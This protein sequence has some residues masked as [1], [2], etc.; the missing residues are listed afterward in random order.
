MPRHSQFA[1]VEATEDKP[2][3]KR[4]RQVFG[5]PTRATSWTPRPV[6]SPQPVRGPCPVLIQLNLVDKGPQADGSRGNLNGGVS[7][8]F[9]KEAHDLREALK[10]AILYDGMQAMKFHWGAMRFGNIDP[11]STPKD[12][13]L[14]APPAAFVQA[15]TEACDSTEFCSEWE[16]RVGDSRGRK[17]E[18]ED[19]KDLPWDLPVP[20]HR[21]RA[22][23]HGTLR[24][25]PP[26]STRNSL[27]RLCT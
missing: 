9:P 17:V 24:L 16:I 10:P 13:V 15:V 23:A 3:R 12:P 6:R 18:L 14:T 7:V 26:S 25:L 27:I 22:T 2:V 20:T 1:D 21:E 19:V 5:S 11:Q 4:P 8:I